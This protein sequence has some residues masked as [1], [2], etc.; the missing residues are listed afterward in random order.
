M[1]PVTTSAQTARRGIQVGLESL[2][3]YVTAIANLER[4]AG[5][6]SWSV[7]AIPSNGNVSTTSITRPRTVLSP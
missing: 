6:A 5:W 7:R 1:S 2:C 3:L 4:H